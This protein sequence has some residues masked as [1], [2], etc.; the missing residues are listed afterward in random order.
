MGCKHDVLGYLRR[1]LITVLAPA[2]AGWQR[3]LPAEIGMAVEQHSS[4]GTGPFSQHLLIM[5]E[6]SDDVQTAASQRKGRWKKLT[7]VGSGPEFSLAIITNISEIQ[8]LV[9]SSAIIVSASRRLYEAPHARRFHSCGV[10]FH[11][12]LQL[13]S[14]QDPPCR[15]LPARIHLCSFGSQSRIHSRIRIHSR[16]HSHSRSR[17]RRGKARR[18]YA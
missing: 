10:H 17:R 11:H 9:Y 18:A 15:I 2:V 16:A 7:M 13:D 5:T 14:C 6:T 3:V 4:S 1:G 12:H 8:H